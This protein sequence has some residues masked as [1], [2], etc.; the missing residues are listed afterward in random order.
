M[1]HFFSKVHAYKC[2]WNFICILLGLSPDHTV[3]VGSYLTQKSVKA[4]RDC[5]YGQEWGFS[6]LAQWGDSKLTAY[7]LWDCKVRLLKPLEN[8]SFLGS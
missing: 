2:T 6:A 5:T 1:S 3:S 7:P 4:P 8:G